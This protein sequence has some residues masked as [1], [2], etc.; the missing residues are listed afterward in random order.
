MQLYQML[1]SGTGLPDGIPKMITFWCV[2]DGEFIGEIQIRPSISEDEAKQMG[3]VGY[4]V[5]YSKWNRGFG[6]KLLK[7]A[8]KELQNLN[9]APIYIACHVDN[10][11]SNHVSKKVGFVFVETRG[12][13]ADKENLYILY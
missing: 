11:G 3:H 2:E 1:E 6:T 9:V 13:G 8:V 7:Y 4:A 5:R 10:L 12:S